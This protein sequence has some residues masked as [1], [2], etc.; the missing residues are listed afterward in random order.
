MCEELWNIL[1]KENYIHEEKWPEYDESLIIKD[2]W[3]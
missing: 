3:N 2:A 1:G